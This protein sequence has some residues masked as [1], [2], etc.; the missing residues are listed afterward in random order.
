MR[1]QL[2]PV[3]SRSRTKAFSVLVL[4]LCFTMGGLSPALAHK[5]IMGLYPEGDIIEGEIGFSNGEMA[6][7]VIVKVFDTLGTKLGETKTD[8]EGLFTYTPTRYIDHV[9]S[10]NLGQGHVVK[11][12]V[13]KDE[14]PHSLETKAAKAPQVI[15]E[16]K[17]PDSAPQ[18]TP[19]LGQFRSN[20]LTSEDLEAA[21]ARAVSKAVR[22]LR[23]DLEAFENKQ[24]L[25][26]ILGGIG[27]II[28]LFGLG[29]YL[30][31]RRRLATQTDGKS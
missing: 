13:S 22:P 2:S 16:K 14:L 7:D 21:I 11:G 12:T 23:K 26:R 25:Q 10:A 6:A 17:P 27:Y 5:V 31:A 19:S 29:F 30:A 28:G 18:A 20:T 1:C 9:F 3:K 15:A 8:D 24:D 4:L